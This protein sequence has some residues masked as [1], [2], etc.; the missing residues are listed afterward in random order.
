[1]QLA[2]TTRSFAKRRKFIRLSAPLGGDSTAVAMESV[3]QEANQ[4]YAILQW[5]NKVVSLVH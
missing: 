5:P 4:S 1:M 2:S 3:A